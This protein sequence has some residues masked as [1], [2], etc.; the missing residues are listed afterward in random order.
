MRPSG[1][2]PDDRGFG[3]GGAIAAG[4]DRVHAGQLAR[5]SQAEGSAACFTIHCS[6]S[7]LTAAAAQEYSLLFLESMFDPA[8]ATHKRVAK[9]IADFQATFDRF[10]SSGAPHPPR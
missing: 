9:H 4:I 8:T 10:D 5:P 3:D 1:W 7:A 2:L 6:T